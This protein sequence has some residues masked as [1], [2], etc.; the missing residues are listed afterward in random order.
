VFD[1]DVAKIYHDVAHVSSVFSDVC[2]KCA[3]LDITY[4]SH[5]C[6]KSMFEMF[7]LFQSLCCN[8]CFYVASC[9]CFIRMLHMFHTHVVSVCSK[10]FICLRR[11]LH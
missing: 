7:H 8:K 1:T 11:M 10:C 6:C 4:V 9:K 2:C 3:Y 5:V